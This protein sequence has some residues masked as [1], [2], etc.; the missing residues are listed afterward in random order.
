MCKWRPVKRKLIYLYYYTYCLATLL[1]SITIGLRTLF[2][3]KEG[4]PAESR[5]RFLLHFLGGWGW[6]FRTLRGMKSGRGRLTLLHSAVELLT[7]EG[8]VSFCTLGGSSSITSTEVSRIPSTE[9]DDTITSDKMT[10]L[11]SA[12]WSLLLELWTS[13]RPLHWDEE[14]C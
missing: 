6:Q 12:V 1:P 13:L 7:E 2:S 9:V 11:S 4:G 10:T 5:R 3:F 8:A 14:A